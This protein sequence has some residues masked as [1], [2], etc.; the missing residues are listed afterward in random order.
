MKYINFNSTSLRPVTTAI[1]KQT[2]RLLHRSYLA[3]R[4]D[5]LIEGCEEYADM[6]LSTSLRGTK[7]SHAGNVS[8]VGTKQS[9]NKISKLLHRIF[10]NEQNII[11][12]I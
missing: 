6:L 3:L 4:N 5:V 7:Q 2:Q 11:I 12:K 9:P 10:P 1:A 8:L